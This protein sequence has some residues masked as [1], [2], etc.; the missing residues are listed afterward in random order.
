MAHTYIYIYTHTY[1]YIYIYIYIYSSIYIFLF[2]Y[3]IAPRRPPGQ[4][5]FVFGFVAERTRYKKQCKHTSKKA[6][7]TKP[8]KSKTRSRMIGERIKNHP[9]T[10]QNRPQIDQKWSENEAKRDKT[11]NHR[12]QDD[13]G[14]LRMAFPPLSAQDMATT[15]SPKS[16]KN[17]KKTT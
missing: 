15:W 1:I 12:L 14:G 6:S 2:I 4:D 16:N 5:V 8:K 9:E 13:L 10:L 7:K 17:Y 11:S 3:L